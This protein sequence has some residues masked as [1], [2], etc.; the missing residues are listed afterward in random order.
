MPPKRKKKDAASKAKPGKKQRKGPAD[1]AS[2]ATSAIASLQAKI[3]A[4]NTELTAQIDDAIALNNRI[5]RLHSIAGLGRASRGAALEASMANAGLMG[6]LDSL[7]ALAPGALPVAPVAVPAV[8]PEDLRLLSLLSAKSGYLSQKDLDV[9]AGDPSV[10]LPTPFA[11]G[12]TATTIARAQHT[13]T[14]VP[15]AVVVPALAGTA[16]LPVPAAALAVPAA[17]LAAPVL[18]PLPP[19]T[20]AGIEAL[21][22]STVAQLNA[23]CGVRGQLLPAFP[24]TASNLNLLAAGLA[25][26]TFAPGL[27]L[28][29]T[30]A[31]PAATAGLTPAAFAPDPNLAR[32]ELERLGVRE[33]LPSLVS[34]PGALGRGQSD[35]ANSASDSLDALVGKAEA[36]AS[37]TKK[38]TSK[39]HNAKA[40]PPKTKRQSAGG[41]VD[42]SRCILS[43]DARWVIR[44]KE[45]LEFRREHGHCR[46]PH[47]YASNR[48]LSWWVMNQRA[49]YA[50]RAQGQKTWLSEDRIQLLTD[51]G[52]IWTPHSKKKAGSKKGGSKAKKAG[53]KKKASKQ[54]KS[55]KT[56]EEMTQSSDGVFFAF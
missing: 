50:H 19:A 16:S 38:G 46:V 22:P 24:L 55:E 6:S 4:T 8:A 11:P 35:A 15:A 2:A 44:Y 48:K 33:A 5:S 23:I 34:V 10:F 51:I 41:E 36:A 25:P 45:L 1:P 42:V 53:G 40:K 43:R 14:S 52:F 13:A 47:G 54:S 28:P 17:A 56:D 26:S 18:P 31:Y 30:A 7:L 3:D 12:Q 39:N 29:T 9:D 37:K 21:L 32:V 27:A 20:L 49:Q